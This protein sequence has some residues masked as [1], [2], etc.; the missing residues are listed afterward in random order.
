[1]YSLGF[2]FYENCTYYNSSYIVSDL[3]ERN[4]LMD[5]NANFFVVD[6][7]VR[8][9]DDGLLGG[10]AKYVDFEVRDNGCE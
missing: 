7:N 9:N 5:D 4:V 2:A 8:L 6:A 3:H 10:M 1:M